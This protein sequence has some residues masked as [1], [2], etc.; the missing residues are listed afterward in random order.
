[1]DG[2]I[3][4]Y[5]SLFTGVKPETIYV[6]SHWWNFTIESNMQLMWATNEVIKSK[7]CQI[8]NAYHDMWGHF[9]IFEY[10]IMVR[11]L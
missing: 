2:R 8:S 11:T 4:E 1:M 6:M 3:T 9:A 10:E 7:Q 5:K